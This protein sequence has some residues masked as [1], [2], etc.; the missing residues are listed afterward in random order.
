MFNE[1]N[2]REQMNTEIK[3]LL[4]LKNQYDEENKLLKALEKNPMTEGE[5]E[6]MLKRGRTDVE[7]ATIQQ[8]L[9]KIIDD[10]RK[11]ELIVPDAPLSFE[12]FE[13]NNPNLVCIRTSTMQ[14]MEMVEYDRFSRIFKETSYNVVTVLPPNRPDGFKVYQDMPRPDLI[15]QGE[16]AVQHYQKKG[17]GFKLETSG[18]GF[19]CRPN[20]M[21]I[22]AT[23]GNNIS[24]EDLDKFNKAKLVYQDARIRIT[25]IFKNL[26]LEEVPLNQRQH[27]GGMVPMDAVS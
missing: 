2:E 24:R 12:E 21:L 3:E 8:R 9:S 27:M 20:L 7:W 11:R 1:N 5:F 4:E 6:D 17:N 19:M 10:L 26:G 22:D 16:T 18:G 23:G 15:G 13:K 14:Q 25:K